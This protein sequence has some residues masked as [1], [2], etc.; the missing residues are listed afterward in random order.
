V[1]LS[2]TVFWSSFFS[3]VK[4]RPSANFEPIII[5]VYLLKYSQIIC[6]I[7]GCNRRFYIRDT[8]RRPLAGIAVKAYRQGLPLDRTIT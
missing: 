5:I 6:S 8:E 2:Q 3:E 4:L 7:N 1:G